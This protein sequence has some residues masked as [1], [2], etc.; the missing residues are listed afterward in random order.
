[1]SKIA[2]LKPLRGTSST[3]ANVVLESG[4]IAFEYPSSGPGTGQGNIK[5][6]DGSTTYN[7]LPDYIKGVV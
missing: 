7:N 3:L 2:V 5:M 4:E 1:M 6:G